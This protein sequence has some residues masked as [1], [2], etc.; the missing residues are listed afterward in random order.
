VSVRGLAGLIVVAAVALTP[1]AARADD[2]LCRFSA[3]PDLALQARLSP[4]LSPTVRLADHQVVGGEA[5]DAAHAVLGTQFA[6]LFLDHARHQWGVAFA[7]GPL[8]A[9][10]ARAAIHDYLAARLAPDDVTFL[11]ST[12]GLHAV[13]YSQAELTVVQAAVTTIMQSTHT[14]STAGISCGASD[15]FRVEVG[16]GDPETPELRAQVE[17]LLAP[18]GDKVVITYGVG[19]A[20]P[21]IGY[22]PSAAGTLPPA[23]KPPRVR[24]YVSVPRTSRCV[25]GRTISVKAARR[26]DLRSVAVASGA[27]HA[28]AKPGRRAKLKLLKR[29]TRI[30]VTVSLK[31]GRKGT[32]ALTYR[33]C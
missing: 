19:W 17:A 1:A 29:K 11:D 24:D 27:R 26:A 30:T 6:G 32:Q 21:A 7:P 33:R 12:L 28:S 22:V 15:A 9:A 16:I 23:V 25:K 18:Y 8:D 4:F 2:A 14:I 20:V 31:D 10:A 13:P 5:A 3:P